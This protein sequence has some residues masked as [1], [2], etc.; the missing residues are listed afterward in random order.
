MPVDTHQPPDTTPGSLV[1]AI[2]SDVRLLALQQVALSKHEA[3][4]AIRRARVPAGMAALGL[5][6]L[7]VSAGELAQA[8][9]HLLHWLASPPAT[10]PAWAPLW[11]C[12][13]AAALVLVA[14]GAPLVYA[15]TRRSGGASRQRV[16]AKNR[17][18]DE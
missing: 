17:G 8:L 5:V 18:A 11:Q 7:L 3:R 1:R 6:A 9:T 4:A 16:P 12:H 2:V 14:V 10:D 13:A 15:A